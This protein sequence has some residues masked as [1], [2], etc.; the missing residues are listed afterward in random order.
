MY[1]VERLQPG[2]RRMLVEDRLDP[3]RQRLSGDV[4]PGDFPATPAAGL[5]VDFTPR[6]EVR[7]SWISSAKYADGKPSLDINWMRVLPKR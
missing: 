6:I 3:R 1:E 7:P 5:P 4:Y 2:Q